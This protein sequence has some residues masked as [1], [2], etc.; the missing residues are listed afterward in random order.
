MAK[1][2][3]TMKAGMKKQAGIVLVLIFPF[4]F[5]CAAPRINAEA[6]N[7]RGVAYA[8]KGQYDQAISDY[9][10]ALEMNPRFAKAYYNRGLAYWRKGQPDQAIPITLWSEKDLKLWG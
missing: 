8:A 5:S 9:N 2:T 7:N 3:N 1:K 10:K 4:L 6:Y